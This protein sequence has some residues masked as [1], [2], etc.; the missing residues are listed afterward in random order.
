MF[1]ELFTPVQS[2]AEL[3]GG[4]E[5]SIDQVIHARVRL[6]VWRNELGLLAEYD[7]DVGASQG[8]EYAS[9][10]ST[11]RRANAPLTAGPSCFWGQDTVGFSMTCGRWPIRSA[12]AGW[13]RLSLTPSVMAAVRRPRFSSPENALPVEVAFP[14]APSMAT[15]T[16]A[17]VC[18]RGCTPAGRARIRRDGRDA[19][20]NRQTALDW[21]ALLTVLLPDLQA[22]TSR[23]GR[24]SRRP[25]R[26]HAQRAPLPVGTATGDATK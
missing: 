18:R 9:V 19:D 12:A 1:Q 10:T 8:M 24:R 20:C 14:G 11:C 6:P 21:M 17:T 22:G 7:E 15:P 16:P 3:D 13:R 4:L 2:F 5:P 23:R 25:R 26:L